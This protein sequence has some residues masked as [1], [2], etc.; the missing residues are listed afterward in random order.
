MNNGFFSKVLRFIDDYGLILFTGFLI[1]F[2]PLYPK[3]P[4]FSPIEQYNVRVRMEDAFVLMAAILWFIQWLRGKIRWRSS[5]TWVIGAYLVVGLLSVLNAIFIIQTVPLQPLHLGKTLLHYFRYIEYFSLFFISFSAIQ[6][7]KQVKALLGIFSLTVVAA[8]IYGYG[9]KFYYWPVYSTMNREFSKGVRLYLT[10]HARV[11][12][13]F[14]GHYDLGAFLVIAL[15]IILAL[16][17]TVK[18]KLLKVGLHVAHWSGVWLL[19]VSASRT[20]FVAYAGAVGLVL[21]ILG[22]NQQGWLKKISWTFTRSLFLGLLV[23]ITLL[24]YGQDMYDRFL[25]VLEG[26]PQAYEQYHTLNGHRKQLV[27]VYIPATL[28]LREWPKPPKAEVPKNAI[29]TDDAARVIVRSDQRPVREKPSD[30]YVD[31]PDYVEVE[32]ATVS[33]SGS[34]EVVTV[35]QERDRVFSDCSKKRGL[36]LC[37][38][39]ETLWPQAIAGF[40][41]SPLFGSG[42]ATLNKESAQQFTEADST[43]NNFLRT[44]GETGLLGFI[45]FYAIVGVALWYTYFA[46]RSQDPLLKTLAIGFF[47]ATMGLLVNAIYIDVFA[48]SKVAFTYWTLTGILAAYVILDRGE[49]P[50]LAKASTSPKISSLK[51]AIVASKASTSKK[52]SKETKADTKDSTQKKTKKKSKK[53]QTSA[54]KKRKP[55]QKNHLNQSKVV[56]QK[57]EHG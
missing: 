3:I 10:E 5:F 47:A 36:S 12:S 54:V 48:S 50:I 26:Y 7:K 28:G 30:V 32:V 33:A 13:T 20:S 38:R 4:F 25:Q 6:S 39:L 2:I 21:L 53:K 1:A 55:A 22:I 41:R 23:S 43:D 14:A 15:P 27:N 46:Y 45:T 17:F 31:V 19:V 8:A 18:N 57:V 9:Q 37:I 11:Q 40:T 16:A 35:I 51:E 44:L 29:S 49:K 34:A 52:K 42:Y 56:L 24:T